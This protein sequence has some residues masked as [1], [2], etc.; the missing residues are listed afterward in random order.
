MKSNIIKNI[1]YSGLDKII[2]LSIQLISSIIIVRSLPSEDLGVIG[3]TAGAFAI[4]NAFNVAIENV[5]IKEHK[6]FGANTSIYLSSLVG[7]NIIKA[8]SFI[9][10]LALLSWL[11]ALEYD[12]KNF[13]YATI[14][15]GSV[16]IA[17]TLAAPFIVYYATQF[18]QK[19][20]T[21]IN[22]A[23]SC[24]G[25]LTLGALYFWPKIWV[26]AIKDAIAGLIFIAIW[27][28]LA[29]THLK[30]KIQ[31]KNIDWEFIKSAFRGYTSWVH[32]NGVF[33]N[34]IYKSDTLF[35]SIFAPLTVVGNY[36]I[37]LTSANVA[38]AFP[39]ILAYQNT[40]ALSHAKDRAHIESL[41]SSFFRASI[42][43]GIITILLFAFLGTY[44]LQI[45]TGRDHV[46][47]IY[48]YMM[49][50]VTGL[51]LAK[52]A[53]SPVVAYLN[54]FGSVKSIALKIGLPTAIFSALAY[55]FSAKEHGVI[56][57]AIANIVIG[58]F[59]IAATLNEA[60]NS[61]YP[62][63]NTREFLNDF[64]RLSFLVRQWREKN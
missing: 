64:F 62:H 33:T 24:L 54:I 17:D 38:N 45:M 61:K 15:A 37:A 27:A 34:L 35:L 43:L 49:C 16:L 39:M 44:Y 4:F 18:N 57:V 21:K 29:K 14:S 42:Y 26:L 7:V 1:F 6:N 19:T 51:A 63:T 40:I 11:L 32:L 8:F 23:R 3:V 60:K 22:L 10:L 55:Y 53:T 2:S 9:G 28:W 47:D 56:G 46:D 59:W 30:I 13:I 12:N 52:A 20:I 48:E 58:V 5:I 25:L 41:A 36:N 50:I 31:L